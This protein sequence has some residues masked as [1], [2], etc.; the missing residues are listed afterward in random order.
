M[1]KTFSTIKESASS[2]PF[3]LLSCGFVLYFDKGH[4]THPSGLVLIFVTNPDPEVL[5]LHANH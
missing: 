4:C 3:D 5:R 2:I 1:L